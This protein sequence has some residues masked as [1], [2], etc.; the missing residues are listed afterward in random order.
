MTVVGSPGLLVI[1]CPLYFLQCHDFFD[2]HFLFLCGFYFYCYH[3]HVL[4]TRFQR[5]LNTRFSF[6]I[7]NT[8][9]YFAI[10]K[11]KIIGNFNHP[12]LREVATPEDD[13]LELSVYRR[14]FF[15]SYLLYFFPYSI[16]SPYLLLRCI[17]VISFCCSHVQQMFG[18][19]LV[20]E[21]HILPFFAL[22]G[23]TFFLWE[24]NLTKHYNNDNNGYFVLLVNIWL[25]TISMLFISTLCKYELFL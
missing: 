3:S 19:T 25:V 24:C 16:S 9:K 10:C 5:E 23:P 1:L 8:V 17:R 15:I 13:R 11:Q 21:F 18:K 6:P 14:D 7:P 4:G 22:L 2:F 20:H 12:L